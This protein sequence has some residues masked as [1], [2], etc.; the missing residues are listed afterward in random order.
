MGRYLRRTIVWECYFTDPEL[1][2][3]FISSSNPSFF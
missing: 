2:G 1:R 3:N